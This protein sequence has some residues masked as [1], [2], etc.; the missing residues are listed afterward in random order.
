MCNGQKGSLKYPHRVKW[1]K[2]RGNDMNANT[3]LKQRMKCHILWAASLL[4]VWLMSLWR[5]LQATWAAQ[6]VHP[7]DTAKLLR[8]GRDE[9]DASIPRKIHKPRH[10][11]CVFEINRSVGVHQQVDTPTSDCTSSTCYQYMLVYIK[12][13]SHEKKKNIHF[14]AALPLPSIGVLG[15]KQLPL[16]LMHLLYTFLLWRHQTL[17]QS[18]QQQTFV[19]QTDCAD[20]INAALIGLF[21]PLYSFILVDSI[22][23]EE[24]HVNLEIFFSLFLLRNDSTT[25]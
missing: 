2:E 6:Q 23:P 16:L 3:S 14:S 20:G 25:P 13:L 21:P 1:S 18:P 24:E 7:C 17:R 5:F 8:G 11:N 10:H 12:L 9:P 19:C 15:T 4:D 22:T